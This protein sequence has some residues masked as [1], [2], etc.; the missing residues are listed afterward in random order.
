[1]KIH[2]I[3]FNSGYLELMPNLV[4]LQLA[5]H[6]LDVAS[7]HTL[8]AF[9]RQPHCA[10]KTLVLTEC[11][12][13]TE[14]ALILASSLRRENDACEKDSA[15]KVET[16]I[17]SHNSISLV[18]L[19][20]LV[21]FSLH[22][23]FFSL[24]LSL[25]AVVSQLTCPSVTN[26]DLCNNSIGGCKYDNKLSFVARF[27]LYVYVCQQITRASAEHDSRFVQSSS[28]EAKQQSTAECVAHQQVGTPALSQSYARCCMLQPLIDSLVYF[29]FHAAD[30]P[31]VWSEIVQAMHDAASGT[32]SV[33]DAYELF[34]SSPRKNILT[35]LPTHALQRLELD[36]NSLTEVEITQCVGLKRLSL[37][38]NDMTFP[39][40]EV[41]CTRIFPNLINLEELDL[42]GNLFDSLLPLAALC[43]RH[44]LSRLRLISVVQIQMLVVTMQRFIGAIVR[45]ESEAR[46]AHAQLFRSTANHDEV[47]PVQWSVRELHLS[48][49]AY[50]VELQPVLANAVLTNI[51]FK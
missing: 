25:F 15:S 40:L 29:F 7:A 36:G 38:C 19:A 32:H 30:A 42:S 2:C 13:S 35:A 27:L 45:A 43:R 8:A 21:L 6:P 48:R 46:E 16:V 4:C 22:P 12:L 33:A 34:V 14:H 20:A 49:A 9:L 5:R 18:G 10:V 28:I 24:D 1:V 26:L 3:H 50:R 11:S 39:T 31:I 41:L 47:E 44:V 17:L 51:V 37:A 23:P